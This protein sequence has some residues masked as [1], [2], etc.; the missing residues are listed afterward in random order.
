MEDEL[1]RCAQAGDAE[2]FHALVLRYSGVAWR[3]ARVLLGDSGPAEDAVQEAWLDAWRGL[4][5]FQSDRPF[6]PWLLR[7]VA[8]RC[9]MALRKRAATTV[10][11]TEQIAE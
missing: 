5:R 9:R 3:T 7:L 8:N 11:L 6:R 4:I 10:R 2:A 1:I